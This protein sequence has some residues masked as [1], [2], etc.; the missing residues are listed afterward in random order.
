[1]MTDLSS[2]GNDAPYKIV[3]KTIQNAANIT[4]RL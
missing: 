4:D 3:M 2:S 1:M